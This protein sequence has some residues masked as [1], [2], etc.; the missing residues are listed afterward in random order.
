VYNGSSVGYWLPTDARIDQGEQ[1]ISTL[2]VAR[3][4]RNIAAKQILLVSDSC[5]SGSLSYEAA[6]QKKIELGKNAVLKRRSV[7]VLT[8]GSEEP[9]ADAG[10]TGLSPFASSFVQSIHQ[11]SK[12]NDLRGQLLYKNVYQQVTRQFKQYP[13]YGGLD[14]AGNMLGGEYIFEKK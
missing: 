9:V 7:M 12:D 10:T 11:V 5:F 6:F 8:S 1:W 3:F 2:D 14:S 4:V 13:T